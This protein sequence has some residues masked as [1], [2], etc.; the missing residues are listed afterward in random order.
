MTESDKTIQC[1]LITGEKKEVP[2]RKLTFRPAAYALV[3]DDPKLLL[4]NTKSTGKWFFPGGAIEKGE[5]TEEALRREVQEETG[6]ILNELSFFTFKESFFYYEPHNQ[7]YHSFNLFYIATPK[8]M[9][10]QPIENDQ[11]D[12]ADRY[13]W[14]DAKSLRLEDMQSFAGEI[15]QKFLQ[16]IEH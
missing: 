15:L 12:E 14:V 11:T 3:Y 1:E 5:K 7:G 10:S 8:N 6:I 13:E 4:V 9:E 16:H 2:A